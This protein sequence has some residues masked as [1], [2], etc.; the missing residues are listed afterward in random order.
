MK[1]GIAILSAALL[2]FGTTSMMDTP[3]AVDP[4]EESTPRV[5]AEPQVPDEAQPFFRL[6]LAPESIDVSPETTQRNSDINVY[7][8]ALTRYPMLIVE[9]DPSV[10]YRILEA[11]PDPNVEYR[12]P[13]VDPI[14]P[15]LGRRDRNSGPLLFRQ[16]PDGFVPDTSEE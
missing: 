9:T 3:A 11:T 1:T 16:A 15:S 12:M 2:L 10:D 14:E 5:E 4:D 6:E 13:M 8:G 7:P